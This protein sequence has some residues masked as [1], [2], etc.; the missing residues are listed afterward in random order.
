V[1]S[2]PVAT[3]AAPTTG[4][5]ALAADG[6]I[7]HLRP[8]R[9]EDRDALRE[10]YLSVSDESRHFRFFSFGTGQ[11][12][13][14]VERLVRPGGTDHFAVVALDRER[15]VG[16][17]SYE[18]L[19]E[20]DRAE[21]AVLVADDYHGRGVGTLLLEELSGQA[22]RTGIREIV[23]D[24]LA[25]NAGMLRVVTGFAPD[26]LI[27]YDS[28]V[29][30]VCLPTDPD[31]LALSAL[32]LRERTAERHSLRPLLAPASV[33]VAGAGRTPGGIGHEVLRSLA[34]NFTGRLYAVNPN[35]EE[36][37]GV[38]CYSSVSALPE[39]VD[40]VVVAVPAE[41]VNS[42]LADAGSAGA[43]T[44]VVLTS[45]LGE[46][47]P[48][49]R[50]MQAEV[51]RTAR[52]NG[53]RL[54]GPN[55]L[56]V[57]NADPQV[58]LAGTFAGP[59]P[60][61]G[62]L[63]VASQS[64]AVGIA[65]LEHAARTGTG[66]STF[67]SLGNKADVSGNDL[68]AYWYDD[69]ATRAVALYLESFG[70]PRKFARV[71]RAVARRKPVLAVKS[72]RSAGGQRAGASHTAAAAAPEVAVDSL[73]AQA[74]V[75]RTDT[76]GELLDA[77]RMLVD[78]PLPAGFRLG[79]VGNA[80]GF[81]VLAADAADAAGLRVPEAE[82]AGGNPVDLGA[83]A[84]PAELGRAL[85]RMAGS[86]E[87]DAVLAV[88]CATRA[89]DPADAL[90][91]IG[92]AADEVSELPVAVVLIGFDDPPAH[93]GTRRAPVYALPEQAVRALGHGAQYA[94]WRSQPLGTRPVLTDVYPAKARSIVDA[95]LAAGG[96]W[97]PLPV[98]AELLRCYGIPVVP[99]VVTS[100]L[101]STVEAADRIGYPVVV[102]AADP[103]IVHK[104]DLGLVRLGLSSAQAVADAY[105]AIGA[106]LRMRQPA[107]V[108]QPMRQGGVELVAGVVHDRLFGSLV[109]VG[110]GGV[111][112]DL[113]GDRAFQLLPVTDVDAAAMWRRLRGAPLLTGFRGSPPGDTPALDDLLVR[114]GRFA[115]DLPEVAELDLNPLLVFPQGVA[116]VDAKLRLQRT[117]PEPDPT[118]RTLRQP[119]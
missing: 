70:N 93:L 94:N 12:D 39:P 67:V 86:G 49:G 37:A 99:S 36:V 22:R 21:F 44:A 69:E 97:Q 19:G 71:A 33:A 40:L 105:T 83:G 88:F 28:G 80:G 119:E 75:V 64:G 65:I 23:G 73:F 34:E 74:G 42:V 102:K 46:N 104:S 16:A 112:T 4:H 57:I 117:G 52:A 31:E 116:A 100:D 3:P 43:R 55:C 84:A 66:V 51:L 20:S 27:R 13:I 10:L 111:H 109:M 30:H 60:G 47:G 108:V 29:M 68:L 59:L 58:R 96:G 113:L 101:E 11:V 54:V 41:A 76:L 25:S 17:A 82:A 1:T 87:V 79:I 38:R 92:R 48:H 118:R 72:G 8:V 32:D 56:G 9:P 106:T 7:V 2:T 61:S 78:Q 14:E 5:D 24:V 15:L 103:G 62:G 45:G 81:N 6:R 63:A 115:E 95:A 91:A 90:A 35:A 50:A 77:A 98:I 26:A 107:V 53:I 89:N 114:L 110:L 85:L 18:R